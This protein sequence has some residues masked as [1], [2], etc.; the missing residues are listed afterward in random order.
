[1]TKR[2]LAPSVRWL[3]TIWILLA[4]S[5]PSV[6]VADDIPLKRTTQEC[7]PLPNGQVQMTCT[8]EGAACS[9]PH[10]YKTDPYTSPALCTPD[11][12]SITIPNDV[13]ISC[14]PQV[15][16]NAD[17]TDKS[18]TRNSAF[19]RTSLYDP[20][21]ALGSC[22]GGS[23]PS[24][25]FTGD[26]G[27]GGGYAPDCSP[28]IIDVDGTGFDLTSAENGVR[29]DI[30]GDGH[31]VQIAWT[32]PNSRNA[33]LA[34]D[35]NHNGRI[36][37]GTELFGNFTAQPKSRHPNGFLALAEFDKPE[38]GGN[39]DGVI[40]D[41]DAVFPYLLLWI[42]ENHDGIAQP[43][44]LHP[45]AELGVFSL[46]LR[47]R[48]ARRRD[49]F[50]NLFRYKAKVNPADKDDRDDRSEVGPWAYDVFLVTK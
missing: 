26:P 10:V 48:E 34:L 46:G 40:D 5:S 45:L 31:P 4:F 24:D 25:G 32:A 43:G 28:I 47:Y 42:D 6:C 37:D 15:L 11:V 1:M 7:G 29:F 17:C 39:G 8:F 9:T 16:V 44:E 50:G 3:M 35:R 22:L 49:A 14:A 27:G 41:H 36:D 12:N 38:N 2:S 19:V 18:D 30:R 23:G 13:E 20:S 21:A 33:F